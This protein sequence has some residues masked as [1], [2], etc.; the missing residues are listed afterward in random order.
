MELK[1][2]GVPASV[3]V[4]LSDLLSS[5]SD[6]TKYFLD[7]RSHAS[8]VGPVGVFQLS[9]ALSKLNFKRSLSLENMSTLTTLNFG[10]G[11]I[12]LPKF[13]PGLYASFLSGGDYRPKPPPQAVPSLFLS[14]T[15]YIA[16]AGL[17]YYVFKATA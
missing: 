7:I 8:E 4:L 13:P 9:S 12:K 2:N 6:I 10:K 5:N 17:Y 16:T 15:F 14:Q 11:L 3:R 1:I